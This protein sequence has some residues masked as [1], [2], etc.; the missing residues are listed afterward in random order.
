MLGSGRK[1]PRER[2]GSLSFRT[3]LL[4]WQPSKNVNK[5]KK[6]SSTLYLILSYIACH[7]DC[8]FERDRTRA[9]LL[10]CCSLICSSCL[11]HSR[12]YWLI[13]VVDIPR[14]VHRRCAYSGLF[15]QLASRLLFAWLLPFFRCSLLTTTAIAFPGNAFF[16]G[17]SVYRW[18][19][20]SV[21]AVLARPPTFEGRLSYSLSGRHMAKVAVAPSSGDDRPSPLLTMMC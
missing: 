7:L 20:F 1:R 4:G 16:T 2:Q 5:K 13:I 19:P 8:A 18:A 6:S 15:F 12:W 11:S 21:V 9:A 3:F 10:R 17:C 14:D